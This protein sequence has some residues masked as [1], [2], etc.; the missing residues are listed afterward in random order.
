MRL[1][2][3]LFIFLSATI[4]QAQ[5]STEG[6]AVI[7]KLDNLDNGS[8]K[9]FIFSDINTG[10]ITY[11]V[12]FDNPN[13]HWKRYYA[14]GV[15]LV[16]EDITDDI[17]TTKSTT[18]KS[19][20]LGEGGYSLQY[21]SLSTTVTKYIWIVDYDKYKVD[22]D[23][24]GVYEVGTIFNTSVD[25][26]KNLI[27][28]TYYNNEPAIY[29]NLPN[30]KLDSINRKTNV[31]YKEYKEEVTVG[32]SQYLKIAAPYDDKEFEATV[33]DRFTSAIS[34]KDTLE[35]D[36]HI[37]DSI[38]LAK[39][40]KMDV[41]NYSILVD[42]LAN[43]EIEQRSEGNLGGSA[44]LEVTFSANNPS[45]KVLYYDW[46]IS[47][48]LD[49]PGIPIHFIE[50]EIRHT[51]RELINDAQPDYMTKLTI[52]NDYC[53]ESDSVDITI[54]NSFIDAPNFMVIKEGFPTEFRV[55]YKSLD[56]FKGY[57]YNRWGRKLYE[58]DDPSR[59]W[60]MKHRGKYVSPGVYFYVVRAKGTDGYSQNK[61]GSITIIRPNK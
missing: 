37:R 5:F 58:W 28:K 3:S 21:D 59:G 35:S 8:G 48:K 46:Y 22:I 1:L 23:S 42:S 43:N 6:N 47:K 51:F 34:E 24:I 31:T 20:N 60:D 25:Y 12:E 50:P 29:F 55:V 30:G 7:C 57:I 14:P 39:A 27:L 11:T 13:F 61:S 10:T 26:C 16:D 33:F 40:V 9:G 53:S 41:I 56:T 4:L 52:S 2:L 32:T 44:P 49:N 36:T 15:G 54:I 38:Y 18:I 19:A 17:A 45:S